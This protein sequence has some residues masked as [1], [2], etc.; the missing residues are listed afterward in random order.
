MAKKN[1]AAKAASVKALPKIRPA[2]PDEE[3]A[4]R[5]VKL[6]FEEIARLGF[7]RTLNLDSILNAY[8]YSLKRL[9][10]KEENNINKLE[11][12]LLAKELAQIKFLVKYNKY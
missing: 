2:V 7:K 12:Y 11:I 8:F 6:Y 1:K 5:L 3:I 9:M 4:Y 10:N